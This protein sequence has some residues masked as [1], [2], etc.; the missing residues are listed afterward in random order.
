[1]ESNTP[2]YNFDDDVGVEGNTNLEQYKKK[3]NGAEDEK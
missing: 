1:V 2:E 3:I